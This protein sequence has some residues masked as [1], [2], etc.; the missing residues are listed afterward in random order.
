[1]AKAKFNNPRVGWYPKLYGNYTY[2]SIV[3]GINYRTILR[4]MNNQVECSITNALKLSKALDTPV[5]KL[6]T[7][8]DD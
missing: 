7:L 1:M 6:F 3:T 2:L 5:E 8:K 4:I